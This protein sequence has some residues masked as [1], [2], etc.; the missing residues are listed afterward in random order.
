MQDAGTRSFEPPDPDLTPDELIA[1]AT[2]LRGRL[3]ERQDECD[4]LGRLP[5]STLQDYIDAGFWRVVQPRRFGGYE[6]DL[7]T[8]L[9]VTTELSRGCPSSGW[10]F[11]L[12][13]AHNLIVGLFEEQGQ[14]QLF[15]DGDFRCP[16][17]NL[18]APAKKVDGGYVVSGWWDYSSG[19]DV[20]THFIGG[21]VITE[22]DGSIDTRWVA[23][24]RD[25]Y[26]IIDNWDTLGMRGTGSR[27]VTVEDLFIPTHHTVPSPNPFRPVVDF[28]GRDVHANP[29]FRGPLASLL[30]SEPAAVCVGIAQA[31]VDEY[32]ELLTT[33]HQYGPMSPLRRDLHVFQRLLGE[34]TAYCDTAEAALRQVAERWTELAQRSAQTGEPT[35]DEDDRRLILMEQQVIELASKT[36]ELVFRTSGS[37][38]SNKGQRIERYFRDLNMVR[39]HVTLQFERTWENVGRLRL[40]LVPEMGF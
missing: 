21:A 29:Q 1:R 13:A 15:G 8:F 23:I 35:S 33:K 7:D 32:I 18:P 38:A 34:A 6:F 20:A 10:V 36:V 17:S 40:G 22:D 11:G 25:Q 16:L 4:G 2:A 26:E 14:I 31:A 37:S 30:I 28:P 9:R 3:R 12:T 39:T 19:C 5:D 27:R 24:R